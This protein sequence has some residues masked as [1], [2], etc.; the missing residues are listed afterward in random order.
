MTRF[1]FRTDERHSVF[2]IQHIAIFDYKK[3]QK[4]FS[5]EMP[6]FELNF[7]ILSIS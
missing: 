7:F 1:G 6:I 2:L 5:S 4:K 3:N